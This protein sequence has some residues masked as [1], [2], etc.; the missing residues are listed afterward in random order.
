[1]TFKEQ[2]IITVT[3]KMLPELVK[4]GAS[5]EV[6]AVRIKTV[7]DE[8]VNATYPMETLGEPVSDNPIC[9]Y[10]Q[11]RGVSCTHPHMC[12]GKTCKHQDHFSD[13]MGFCYR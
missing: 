10:Y 13:C 9:R 5:D 8:I 1:M 4:S 6:I 7:V 12:N 3:E 2:L 11:E